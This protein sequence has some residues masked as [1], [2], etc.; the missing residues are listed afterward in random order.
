MHGVQNV[1]TQSH[2]LL[3][4]QFTGDLTCVRKIVYNFVLF[5]YYF[6]METSS[7]DLIVKALTKAIVEHR[8]EPGTKLAEQK[9]ADHHNVSRTLVRQALFRMSQNR[10]VRM[11]P[12]RGAF[13]ASPSV[14][15][16]KQVFSVRRMLECNMA[17]QFARTATPQ[18]IKILRAHIAKEQAAVSQTD[19]S[20]RTELLGN[21]HVRIAE[22]L[23]NAV[24]ADI[25]QDLISRC[26]LV[27]L[28][29]QSTQD[30]A[31]SSKEHT[32]LVDAM[33]AKDEQRVLALMSEHLDGVE[34]SLT[35]TAGNW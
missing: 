24:L 22:L 26:A 33:E 29:Y 3:S 21:F 11:E 10:L 32:I 4:S 12:A 1:C 2:G 25:L 13:V 17:M 28:M 31:C 7:T 8:L 5:R 18:K 23:D 27:T 15:E 30:A 19:P 16:A 20:V 6:A 34:R 9:L 14:E 35:F